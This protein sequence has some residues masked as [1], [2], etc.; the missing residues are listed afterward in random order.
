MPNQGDTCLDGETE[1]ETSHYIPHESMTKGT[2]SNLKDEE[3]WQ[4]GSK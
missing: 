3:I 1:N 4:G 2:H